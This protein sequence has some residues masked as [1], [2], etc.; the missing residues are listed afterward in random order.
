MSD[1]GR[2]KPIIIIPPETMSKEDI[3]ELRDNGLC[4]VEAADPSR[5]KFLD[6]IPSAAE[7]TKH[8]QAAIQLSRKI[9]S[10]NF[11]DSSGHNYPVDRSDVAK[12]YIELL[13]KG[14]S[15]DPDPT[16]AEREIQ[17]FDSA[18]ADELRRLAREEAKADRQAAK[19]A[20]QKVTNAE[21]KK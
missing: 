15:L 19:A 18:K 7:R 16:A 11:Y 5:V 12:L 9:L 10:R 4:V 6:P 17:I 20:K 21:I 14:T 13:V 1:N 8:E 3:K 2:M